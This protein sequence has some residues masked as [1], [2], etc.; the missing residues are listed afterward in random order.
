MC[1]ARA[2]IQDGK[3]T[4]V[5]PVCY[6]PQEMSGH[7]CSFACCIAAA[8]RHIRA[9]SLST[10]SIT[11]SSIILNGT[12]SEKQPGSSVPSCC[13]SV[14]WYAPRGPPPNRPEQRHRQYQSASGTGRLPRPQ[15]CSQR[16]RDSR[17][18]RHPSLHTTEVHQHRTRQKIPGID[19]PS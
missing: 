10:S 5:G 9:L 6:K 18:R 11:T 2:E 7:V 17:P 13:C 1:R 12:V 4:C 14:Q 15:C 19:P 16:R 3:R 8:D